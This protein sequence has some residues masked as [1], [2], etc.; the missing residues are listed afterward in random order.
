M[1]TLL[2]MTWIELKLFVREPVTMVFTFALPLIFLFVLGGVFKNIP[3]EEF[4]DAKP[5]DY[6][7]PAYVGLVIAS[8][9]LVGL[10]VH[11]AKYRERGVLRRF[12]ASPLPLWCIFGAQVLVSLI[13]ASVGGI[14]LVV[15]SMMAFDVRFPES[16]A[17]VIAG[18]LPSVIA[19]AAIGILL[20]ALLPTTRAAQGLGLILFI[21]ML[22]LSG[23]GP[24]PELMSDVM[25]K[26]GQTMPLYYVIRLIQDPWLGYGWN[27]NGFMILAGVT[28]AASLASL[29][30]FRWE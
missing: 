7:T 12:R 24:P 6:Y 10:P 8:I 17:L 15:V 19:F 9:G 2:K 11:F 16:P 21:V 23:S 20:G 1:R 28:L 29:R 18:F 14:L 30:L 26:T 4:R 13:I 3:S 27:W 25:E 22:M 5:M